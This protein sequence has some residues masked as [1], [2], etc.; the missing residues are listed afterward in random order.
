MQKNELAGKNRI[1]VECKRSANNGAQESISQLQRED[2]SIEKRCVKLCD[3]V[4]DEL[5]FLHGDLGL[6]PTENSYF[7]P[8]NDD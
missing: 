5:R 7:L 4:L 1:F 8:V 3:F 6:Y 2:R